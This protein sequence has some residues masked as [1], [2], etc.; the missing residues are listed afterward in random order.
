LF[1]AC[2]QPG[3][4]P[5]SLL[6]FTVKLPEQPPSDVVWS[7]AGLRRF[8]S[9]PAGP[10]AREV[11]ERLCEVVN[12]F[13]DFDKSF[14]TQCE[15]CELV[16]CYVLVSYFLEAFFAVGYLWPNGETGT[17]KSVLLKVLARLGYLGT[18]LLAGGS[19][20]SLR[21]LSDYG[22]L[23]CFDDAEN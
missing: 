8:R 2:G 1:S 20:A 6:G 5:L 7:G 19:Y 18:F 14:G 17:G 13:V 3:Y 10:D 22:A 21:D 23:L 9:A 16:A 12:H 4:Q 15:M 11:F